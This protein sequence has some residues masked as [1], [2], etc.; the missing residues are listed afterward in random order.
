MNQLNGIIGTSLLSLT[1]CSVTAEKPVARPNF[2]FLIADDLSPRFGCY[3]DNAAMT[4]NLDRLARKGITFTHAYAQGAV[5]IPSRTSFM[6]G[7]NNHHADY[8]YF[9]NP[10]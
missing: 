7:L 9:K 5:C 8:N 2:L 6:L 4:P 1:I 3:G 10:S